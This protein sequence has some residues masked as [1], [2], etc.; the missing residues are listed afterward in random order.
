MYIYYTT[1]IAFC[2]FCQ[3][4]VNCGSPPFPLFRIPLHTCVLIEAVVCPYTTMRTSVLTRLPTYPLT[5]IP[6]CVFPWLHIWALVCLLIYA[7][8]RLTEQARCFADLH[9]YHLAYLFVFLFIRIPVCLF[10]CFC[11]FWLA[12]LRIC[13]FTR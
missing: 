9:L 7:L 2:Q 5:C 4:F 10:A 8:T 1:K 12:Y 3:C 6:L 11:A 13:S